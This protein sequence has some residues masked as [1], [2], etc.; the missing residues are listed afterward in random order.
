MH[1][2]VYLNFFLISC[3]TF[4][5]AETGNEAGRYEPTKLP[6]GAMAWGQPHC[7]WWDWRW[8]PVVGWLWSNAGMKWR[9][10]WLC[11][12]STRSWI[13]SSATA[14]K[15]SW[16]SSKGTCWPGDKAATVQQLLASCRAIA[17]TAVAVTGVDAAWRYD[18]LWWLEARD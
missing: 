13:S 6:D 18:F 3:F 7:C 12:L 10:P 11:F 16:T 8:R 5:G 4:Q 15:H 9:P 2:N 17:A 1:K 14:W